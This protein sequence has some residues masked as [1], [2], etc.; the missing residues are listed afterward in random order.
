[1]KPKKSFPKASGTYDDCYT[2]AYAILPI[3]KYLPIHIWEPAVGEGHMQ[4]ALSACDHEVTGTTDD[5]FGFEQYPTGVEAIVTNPPYS[6]KYD[7]IMQAL[8]FEMPVALLLPVESLGTQAFWRASHIY[9][10]SVIF[11]TPRINFHMPN[12]GWDGAGAQ[13]PT[14]WFMWNFYNEQIQH[15][16]QSKEA[17]RW[18]EA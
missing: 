1:M 4:R 13:F 3:I 14:A 7:W 17:R 11:I 6:I 10:L 9:P 8:S 5:F 18:I 2:P 15:V 12:K 16:H